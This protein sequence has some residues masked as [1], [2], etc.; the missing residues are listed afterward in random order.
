MKV[1]GQSPRGFRTCLHSLPS[2]DVITTKPGPRLGPVSR[3]GFDPQWNAA[4]NAY[5][6]GE[7]QAS[8]VTVDGPWLPRR[9]ANPLESFDK[10]GAAGNGPA[11][12]DLRTF[13]LGN[14]VRRR[15]LSEPP[16]PVCSRTDMHAASQA[17]GIPLSVDEPTRAR[18]RL[19]EVLPQETS[20]SEAAKW[21]MKV[22]DITG[23]IRKGRSPEGF[24]LTTS[25]HATAAMDQVDIDGHR[26]RRR[27]QG[28]TSC[29]PRNTG[30]RMIR[31]SFFA[32]QHALEHSFSLEQHA[33]H[34][35][36]ETLGRSRVRLSLD[37]HRN[38]DLQSNPVTQEG[39]L[40]STADATQ[41]VMKGRRKQRAALAD[42]VLHSRAFRR[43]IDSVCCE[44]LLDTCPVMTA[45][46]NELETAM[47]TLDLEPVSLMG[48]SFAETTAL[49]T[50][51]IGSLEASSA[52]DYPE[53]LNSLPY[54]V[55][56]SSSLSS[57][58][59]K[60]NSQSDNGLNN[61]NGTPKLPQ[62]QQLAFHR[63]VSSLSSK[64][65]SLALKSHVQ[66]PLARHFV[67]EGREAM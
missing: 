67:K 55:R 52:S 4:G 30:E 47:N 32:K 8:A 48:T 13:S 53:T 25:M 15:A 6:H 27:I 46:L 51:Q 7:L 10:E 45:K 41:L 21:S 22:G 38:L 34:K 1:T 44:Q 64:P 5:P 18:R 57:T 35:D 19:S 3:G 26:G 29:S 17:F 43:V 24:A 40:Q 50:S 54:A 37:Q 39:L 42:S 36:T 62:R 61:V 14:G 59:N 12:V 23:I 49:T 9:R 63:V 56:S 28:S 33:L 31:D 58:F 60:E 16:Q 11:R 65:L 66:I 20:R 2:H